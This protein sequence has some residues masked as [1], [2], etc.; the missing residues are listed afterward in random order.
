MLSLQYVALLAAFAFGYF[1]IRTGLIIE[2]PAFLTNWIAA[3]T[4]R[5]AQRFATP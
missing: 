2:P 3:L 5:I 4:E 1:V